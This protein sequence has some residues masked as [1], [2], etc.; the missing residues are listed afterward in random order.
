MGAGRIAVT[1]HGAL[2]ALSLI[3]AMIA[4]R[5]GH[6]AQSDSFSELLA[7]TAAGNL[8]PFAVPEPDSF[9]GLRAI[10]SSELRG[11][12]AADF[13][14]DDRSVL[15]GAIS[16]RIGPQDAVIYLRTN[17]VLAPDDEV[18]ALLSVATMAATSWRS[19]TYARN[20]TSELRAKFSGLFTSCATPAES[21]PTAARRSD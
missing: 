2:L 3:A 10:D 11:T 18:D 13:A 12:K 1:A 15:V 21:S 4:G 9:A 14:S 6:A 7:S 19:C 16:V 17:T 5:G 20:A 8:D